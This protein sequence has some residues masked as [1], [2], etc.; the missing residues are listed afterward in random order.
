MLGI[1]QRLEWPGWVWRGRIGRMRVRV[2]PTGLL[3]LCLAQLVIGL[4]LLWML[5]T[6]VT[7]FTRGPITQATLDAT[8]IDWRGAAI[9][10]PF[11]VFSTIWHELGHVAGARAAGV[12]AKSFVLGSSGR[13]YSEPPA[14][15]RGQL[16]L[17]A[18]GPVVGLTY[19]YLLLAAAP[20][21]TPVGAAGVF[22]VT[23]ALMN[24]LPL[25]PANSDGS[26]TWRAVRILLTR[27]ST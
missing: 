27:G 4:V 22:A 11:A 16:L 18:S 26:A 15:A 1:A 19:G 23:A 7:V 13:I 20:V 24:L 12:P 14:T 21:T 3:A 6:W 2:Y 17:K 25:P 5:P 9:Y 10:V 8:Q